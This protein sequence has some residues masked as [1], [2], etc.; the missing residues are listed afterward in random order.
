MK[1]YLYFC[2][3]LLSFNVYAQDENDR[4][5]RDS[6]T[7][8]MPVEKNSYYESHIN[9]SPFI[10]GPNIL[11]LFPGETVFLEIEH[12]NGKITNIKSVKENK[13]PDRTVEIKFYQNANGNT[14]VSM[15]LKVKNPFKQNLL[16]DAAIR[17]MKS[18][19]WVETSIIPVSAGLFGIEMWP[20]VIVSI[21]LHEWRFVK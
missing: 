14:H 17:L 12:K 16:Y 3:L 8:S 1:K 21:A 11:Q 5:L 7:L 10:V 20:D 18:E 4:P 15:M 9:S 13:N 2:L 6:F 19:K